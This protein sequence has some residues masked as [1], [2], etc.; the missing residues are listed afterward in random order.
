MENQNINPLLARV[1]VPGESF[2]LPSGG[3]FYHDGELS[4]GVMNGEVH[5]HPLTAMDEIIIKNPDKIMS[6]K[7]VIE[8]IKRCVPDVI[9]PSRLFAKDVDFLLI[10]L[11]K[12]TYGADIRVDYRHTCAD[13]K[14]NVYKFSIND[15]LADAKAIDPTTLD[16]MF[17]TKLPNGQVVTLKPMKFAD[18]I[19]MMSFVA[20]SQN[21]AYE[22]IQFKLFDTLATVVHQVDE[23][24][25]PTHIRD[26]MKTIPDLWVKQIN[27]IIVKN[28]D[29]GV[30]VTRETRCKDCGEV[31]NLDIDLNP[32]SF[33]TIYSEPE[34]ASE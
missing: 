20:Q 21:M 24:T 7:G 33:F 14:D 30:K 28:S 8:V 2:R 4:P 22:E 16:Q 1:Q 5:V 31:I 18:V 13:A 34:T 25:N 17:T 23:V 9:D 19:E 12:V 27:K 32:I 10:A 6:G 15:F 3:L 29:W 26:W 11:R